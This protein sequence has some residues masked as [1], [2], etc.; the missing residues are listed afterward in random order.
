MRGER[1][2]GSVIEERIYAEAK[3]KER[4]T[5]GRVQRTCLSCGKDWVDPRCSCGSFE[6]S[7]RDVRSTAMEITGQGITKVMELPKPK[8]VA[9]LTDVFALRSLRTSLVD[10]E[11]RLMDADEALHQLVNV[12]ETNYQVFGFLQ[13]AFHQFT[14]NGDYELRIIDPLKMTSL[15]PAIRGLIAEIDRTLTQYEEARSKK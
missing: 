11:H 3:A 14:A 6:F 13:A 4:L 8:V 5:L 7:E 15:I 9:S 1:E 10:L 2:P 12:N